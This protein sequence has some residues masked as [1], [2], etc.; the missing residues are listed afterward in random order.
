MSYIQDE[1]FII[2]LAIALYIWIES[3]LALL[4][5]ESLRIYHFMWAFKI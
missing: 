3:N 2:R 4:L 5:L 1:I